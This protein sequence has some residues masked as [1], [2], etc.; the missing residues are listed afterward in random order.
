MPE[1]KRKPLLTF[2]LLLSISGFAI[3]LVVYRHL[4]GS[5]QI[6][7][8]QK[9]TTQLDTS[10][11]K[12]ARVA[13]RI[14]FK[15]LSPTAFAATSWQDQPILAVACGQNIMICDLTGKYLKNIALSSTIYALNAIRINNQSLIA[16]SNG[17]S[18]N[19]YDLDSGETI[20]SYLPAEPDSMITDLAI[21]EDFLIAA[22]GKNKTLWQYNR[23]DKSKG[24]TA[25]E[26]CPVG[27]RQFV[28]PGSYMELA[29]Y[30]NTKAIWA[31]NTGKHLIQRYPFNADE[32]DKSWGIASFELEGFSG[33][34]N[35]ASFDILPDGQFITSEKG[36]LL[37]KLFSA[38]GDFIALLADRHDLTRP[39]AFK[40]LTFPKIAA[41]LDNKSFFLLDPVEEEVIIFTIE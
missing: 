22:D 33:C 38:Q 32:P 2:I 12:S 37:V 24:E 26:P 5:Y 25:L 39:S 8:Y 16:Y 36:A 19:I 4:P 28:L 17:S 20:E 3:A 40:E 13:N 9:L 34:C 11:D 15:N 23:Y 29:Y 1:Q 18:A 14:S 30:P 35:P 21:T 31:A 6:F 10:A 41:G 27:N 7:D